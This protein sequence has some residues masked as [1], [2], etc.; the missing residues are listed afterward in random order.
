M[1]YHPHSEYPDDA[2]STLVPSFRSLH[3]YSTLHILSPRNAAPSSVSATSGTPPV[4]DGMCVL[5]VSSPTGSHSSVADILY[6]YVYGLCSLLPSRSAHPR[7]C[8]SVS[9]CRGIA[10]EYLPSVLNTCIS[11]PRLRDTSTNLL[12]DHYDDNLT[13]SKGNI[14]IETKVDAINCVD[15]TPYWILKG[16]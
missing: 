13:Y 2:P 8:I 5:S 12:Y 15:L 16:P 9:E 3:Q 14:F 7:Y 1:T 6:A 11:S 10:S 4:D